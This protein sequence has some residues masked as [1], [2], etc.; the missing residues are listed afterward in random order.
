M[1]KYFLAL[2]LSSNVAIGGLID[3]VLDGRL[4]QLLNQSTLPFVAFGCD[5]G[6][7]VSTDISGL[8]LDDYYHHFLAVGVFM[9]NVQD[10]RGYPSSWIR[11]NNG[12]ITFISRIGETNRSITAFPGS[13]TVLPYVLHSYFEPMYI[14]V[15]ATHVRYIYDGDL[16]SSA[17][18]IVPIT[19]VFPMIKNSA[20]TYPSVFGHDLCL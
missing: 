18:I 17:D 8:I 19:E 10:D 12:E 1:T 7:V 5:Y 13:T 3:E 15:E 11:R 6:G 4:K 9:K 16:R 14:P 2:L 20:D